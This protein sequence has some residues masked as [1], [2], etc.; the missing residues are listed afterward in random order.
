MKDPSGGCIIAGCCLTACP[1]CFSG[2][3]LPFALVQPGWALPVMP[4]TWM[5]LI[6]CGGG[7]YPLL[8]LDHTVLGQSAKAAA[9]SSI[10]WRVRPGSKRK[11]W[12]GREGIPAWGQLALKIRPAPQKGGAVP[13]SRSARG[14]DPR[15]RAPPRVGPGKRPG[16]EEPLLRLRD[17]WRGAEV[18]RMRDQPENARGN[19]LRGGGIALS[20]PLSLVQLPCS[21]SVA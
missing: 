8:V 11:R 13:P 7:D 10:G 16:V 19:Q 6:G 20:N 4:V 21:S 2:R 17:D 9:G 18:F 15:R 3:N 12:F 14:R 1:H 5:E